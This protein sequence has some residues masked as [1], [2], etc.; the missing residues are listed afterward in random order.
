MAADRVR[1]ERSDSRCY[2]CGPAGPHSNVDSHS[3]VRD[4][5]RRGAYVVGLVLL[6]AACSPSRNA[7]PPTSSSRPTPT[8][9]SAPTSTV[10]RPGAARGDTAVWYVTPPGGSA[11]ELTS[12]STSFTAYV[13]RLGCSGGGT[14]PVLEPT[15]DISETAFTV[16]FSVKTLPPGG[17]TCPGNTAVPFTVNLGRPL[18]N[19]QLIDGACRSGGQASTTAWCVNGSVRWR[20]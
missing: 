14:G 18:G 2:E 20:P 17:Y 4:G 3:S 16:T 8:S 10:P 1:C 6:V 5:M 15:V 7:E 12:R 19:R 13:T 11:P 9:S